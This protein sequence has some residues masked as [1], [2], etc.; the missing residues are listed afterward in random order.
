MLESL[1]PNHAVAF[2]HDRVVCA[3]VRIKPGSQLFPVWV[4]MQV[5]LNQGVVLRKHSGFWDI[6]NRVNAHDLRQQVRAGQQILWSGNSGRSGAP[7][8]HLEI[9]VGNEQRCP[10][11][12]LQSLYTAGVGLDPTSLPS[13]GCSF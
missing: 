10:Q 11:Q 8:V 13:A 6:G 2:K 7:H 4:L 12:L 1:Q 9:R 5:L 3:K